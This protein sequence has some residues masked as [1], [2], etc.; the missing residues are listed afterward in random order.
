[1]ADELVFTVIGD[2]ALA[3]ETITLSQAGLRERD[4]LQEWVLAHPEI[5]GPDVLI[6]TCEFDRW[7]SRGGAERDR[8][9]VLGLASD[10][11][12]VVAELKRDTAPDTVEM[13][14]IKYAAMASRF[15]VDTLAEHYVDFQLRQHKKTMTSDEAAEVLAAHT[16]Y[17]LTDET[18]RAPK[19][20]LIAGKFPTNVTTTAVWLSEMGLDMKLIRVQAYRTASDVVITVSQ[21]YPTPDVEDFL[22]APT[23]A[24]RRARSSPLLPEVEWLIEDYEHLAAEVKNVTVLKTLDICAQR[25]G[26]WIASEEVQA[27]TGREPAQHRGDYGGFGTTLKTKFDRS[28]QPFAMKWAAGGLSQQYYSLTAEQAA[29]W[30][31]ARHAMAGDPAPDFP[32]Q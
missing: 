8:L 31:A 28:N 1:M 4:H 12:L 26:V 18:L 5:L 2:T 13:Q 30:L 3:A 27:S 32:E 11:H 29:L 23:R 19:I 16:D 22:V 7:Q 10:G 17:A 24:A 9:D 14:A 25:P 15:D 20:V 6:V 21:Q